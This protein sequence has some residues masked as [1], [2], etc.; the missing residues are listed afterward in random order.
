MMAAG[1]TSPGCVALATEGGLC[2]VHAG[3]KSGRIVP[4]PPVDPGGWRSSVE[5]MH[6]LLR[7]DE[8]ETCGFLMEVRKCELSIPGLLVYAFHSPFATML[9]ADPPK[10]DYDQVHVF[11]HLFGH[12]VQQIERYR[13]PTRIGVADPAGFQGV[14][15]RYKP[16]HE[17]D[18]CRVFEGPKLTDAELAVLAAQAG[19]CR[20]CGCEAT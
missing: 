20:I 3:L 5:E 12:L 1:C 15:G 19:P 11:G 14:P 2:A 10:P 7:E 18:A 16:W 8:P 6:A 9:L 4:R 17:I 13:Q